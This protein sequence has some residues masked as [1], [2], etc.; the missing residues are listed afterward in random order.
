[1]EMAEADTCCGAAGAFSIYHP[2]LSRKVGVRKA[3]NIV[4]TA[5]E[6][7]ATGCPVCVIQLREMLARAGSSQSVA[8]TACVLWEAIM[9]QVISDE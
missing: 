5:A 1:M 4:G 9:E 8:H 2:D 6:I 7:I 3:A